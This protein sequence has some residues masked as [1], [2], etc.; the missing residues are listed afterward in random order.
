[1]KIKYI[2]WILAFPLW[3][4]CMP[5]EALP[6]RDTGTVPEYF[7]ECYCQPGENPVLTATRVVPLT[8]D[9]QYDFPPEMDVA[10]YTPERLK[11]YYMFDSENIQDVQ[12][13]YQ[14]ATPLPTET[15]DT[16]YLRIRTQEQ[17]WI[18][19][20]TT[21]PDQVY[22]HTYAIGNNEAKVRFY[23]SRHSRQNFYIFTL[24]V[25]NGEE[26]IERKVSYLDYS[27]YHSGEL[28]EKSIFCSELATASKAVIL[29]KRITR[30]NYD[31]QISLNGANSAI[32]GSITNPVPLEGNIKGA[33][34][35]F[36]CYTE[37]RKTIDLP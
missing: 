30:E 35:I 21:V 14:S 27:Q 3:S 37:D 10:L 32:Q 29:L 13:N 2:L 31:Y 7:I 12:C 20:E 5:E 34:G 8:G 17:Q 23:T 16:L 6:L 19:A 36:T 26:I 4:A 15:E 22:I 1:M 11:L 25:L 33:L 18:T 24:E 9:I 28:V